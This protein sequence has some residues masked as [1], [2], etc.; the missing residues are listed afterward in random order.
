MSTNPEAG[1]FSVRPPDLYRSATTAATPDR[2]FHQICRPSTRS[3]LQSC[4]ARRSSRWQTLCPAR[5][6]RLIS[7]ALNRRRS[8]LI[9]SWTFLISISSS[10]NIRSTTSLSDLVMSANVLSYAHF[11]RALRRKYRRPAS[12]INRKFPLM[13]LL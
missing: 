3:G 2:R 7:V 8:S 1:S 5:R 13:Q 9:S 10:P 6:R 11:L 4:S 12:P